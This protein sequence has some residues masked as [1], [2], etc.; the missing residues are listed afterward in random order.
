MGKGLLI[1][2]DLKVVSYRIEVLN[3][4][5]HAALSPEDCR[6]AQEYLSKAFELL[7][8]EAEMQG[9]DVKLYK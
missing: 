8:L 1:K 3:R 7:V 9:V 5:F 6:L 4:T 2:E